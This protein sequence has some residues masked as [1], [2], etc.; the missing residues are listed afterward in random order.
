MPTNSDAAQGTAKRNAAREALKQVRSGL[1][2]GLGTGSTAAIFVE[3]LIA[4]VKAEKLDIVG[5]PTSEK[6]RAQAEAGGIELTTLAEQPRIDITFDG[7][8]AIDLGSFCLLKGLG[9]ALLREKIV[10]EASGR[11]V[12]IAD[13]SKVPQPF[14]G[15]VPVEV[16]QFGAAATF[17]RLHQFGETAWRKT[18][19]G[20]RFITDNGNYIA[21]ITIAEIGEPARLQAALKNIA[22]VVETGLFLNQA[23]QL[24]IGRRNGH[25][26]LRS[27]MTEKSAHRHS[28]KFYLEMLALCFGGLA[29]VGVLLVWWLLQAPLR[30]DFAKPAVES[31]IAQKTGL[32]TDIGPSGAGLARHRHT[33]GNSTEQCRRP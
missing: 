30:L 13:T 33:A 20:E 11:L 5:I 15:I 29:M 28:G 10:A 24:I 18:D 3:E 26:S 9:G 21:D 22:G 2:V 12:I 14:G 32:H 17:C 8:D 23:S 4:R 7:A 19:K 27:F 6:T 25:G 1:V 16:V 31:A